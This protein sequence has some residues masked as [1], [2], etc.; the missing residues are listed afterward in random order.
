MAALTGTDLAFSRWM[1]EH[2]AVGNAYLG[3]RLGGGNSNVTQLVHSDAGD[4][5][6]RRPPDDAISESAARGVRREHRILTA[7]AG[8]A[9]VP[10]VVAFCDDDDLWAPDKLARQLAA[11][12]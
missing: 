2:T 1:A 12:P 4:L 8:H 3:R 9:P 7:L 5:V 11:A 10:R 6:L